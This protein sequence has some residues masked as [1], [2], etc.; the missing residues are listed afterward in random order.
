M[1]LSMLFFRNKEMMLAVGVL[2]LLGKMITN[3]RC[4]GAVTALY[5]NL[6]CLEE[7]KAVVGS[8]EAVPFLIG[9]LQH[10]SDLQCKL[11]ALHAI[12]NLSNQPTNITH[13]MSAGI[14]NALL[15]LMTCSDDHAWTEKCIAVLINLT[16][17]KQAQ[18]QIISAPG[19]ISSLGSVLD[20][21]EP[22]EQEQAAAC[23]LVLCNGNEI[24]SQMVLQ[25]GVIPSLV[26]MSVNGTVRGKQKA[27]KLLMLFREQRQKEPSPV[28]TRQQPEHVETP[29]PIPNP[30]PNEDPKPLSKSSSRRKLGK[31]WT[32]FWKNKSLS[33]Y[34]C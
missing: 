12:F 16:S 11:D 34:Q 7:A 25:E 17:N 20:T 1:K 18:H 6:S 14:L 21:G 5:L 27:Q 30:N 19:L 24:C 2:P 3:S 15:T 29:I 22:V 23:L 10:E 8:S 13:L 32:F 26:S 4:I 9:V 31:A 28:K 33:V